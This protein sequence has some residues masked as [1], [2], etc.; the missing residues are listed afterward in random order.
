MSKAIGDPSVQSSGPRPA[1]PGDPLDPHLPVAVLLVG[2][3]DDLGLQPIRIF[4]QSQSGRFRQMLLVSIGVMDYAVIDAG[5]DRERGFEGS[6][7]ARR[8]HERTR[9]SLEPLIGAAR[10]LGIRTDWRI[11]IATDPVPEIDALA[12]EIAAR[13]PKAVFFVSKLV[14]EKPR[15]YQR[16]LFGRRSDEILKRL[17]RRG[18]PVSILPILVPR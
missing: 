8:L 18:I 6:E 14:F 3:Q 17:E 16:L 9:S 4:S 1:E 15:W 10:A 7:E 5:V 11:S 2:G 12:T 13:F